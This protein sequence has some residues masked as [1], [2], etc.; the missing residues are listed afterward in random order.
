MPSDLSNGWDELMAALKKDGAYGVLTIQLK[1]GEPV[2]IAL[3]RTFKDVQQAVDALV[4][5]AGS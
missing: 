2:Q 5:K 1:A 3:N 4:V